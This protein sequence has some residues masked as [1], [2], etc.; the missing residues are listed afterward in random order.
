MLLSSGG[1]DWMGNYYGL[2]KMREATK[3]SAY[4]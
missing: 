2:E 1:L 3:Q 4:F